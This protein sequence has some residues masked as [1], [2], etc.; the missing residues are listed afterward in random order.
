MWFSADNMVLTAAQASCV[1]LPAAGLPVW[2]ARF[3]TGA[4]ALVLPLSIALVVAAIAAAPGTAT[5][6][7]WTALLL[8]PPGCA[9]ALGWAARGARPWLAPLAIPLLALAWAAPE[10]RVGQVATIVLI[11]G[12]AITLGRLLAGV[13]PLSLL[14]AGVVAM[15][16]V[17][18]YLVFSGR[19]QAP[20]AV[21]VAAS[22]G[23]GLPQLQS[24]AFGTAGLGYGDFFAAAVVGGILA[25]EGRRQVA[26]AVA[27]VVVSLVWD[28]LFVVY[29]VLPATIPPAVVLLGA[30]AWRRR[31]SRPAARPAAG[32]AAPRPRSDRR[33]T[34]G[35]A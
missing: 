23:A 29:D 1:A 21:L 9:L 28:Q 5:V 4:W 8:V 31:T 14:K 24:A 16:A 7:A 27:T 15:A 32:A 19:L 12:S 25:A 18:A 10:R 34:G 35:T 22:P 3:R 30:E 33:W 2:A 11:A 26:A 20:N 13:A 6:L 17:D